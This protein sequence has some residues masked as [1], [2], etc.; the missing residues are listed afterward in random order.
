MP[1][2]VPEGSIVMSNSSNS[3]LL[4]D[5]QQSLILGVCGAS[6]MASSECCSMEG[7]TPDVVVLDIIV[8]GCED[9]GNNQRESSDLRKE[10]KK[11][12]KQ[13][14]D[15][16]MGCSEMRN[17]GMPQ[18]KKQRDNSEMAH[19]SYRVESA[20]TDDEL[21]HEIDWRTLD[22]KKIEVREADTCLKV[23]RTAG[24]NNKT[25]NLKTKPK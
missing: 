9:S 24:T 14:T 16:M 8:P 21:C 12:N 11:H 25:E 5:E 15:S 19:L 20:S 7:P 17:E 4:E 22:E 2:R 6:E 1:T 3:K 13:V 18:C 23:H 10:I